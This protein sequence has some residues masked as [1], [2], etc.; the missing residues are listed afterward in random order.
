MLGDFNST[1]IGFSGGHGD[2]TAP[3]GLELLAKSELFG[4]FPSATR[5]SENYTFPSEKPNR[6]IDW[7]LGSNGTRILNGEVFQSKL[8]DHLPVVVEVEF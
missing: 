5:D 6:T 4:L 3:T 1:P 8:S 2:E 7:I